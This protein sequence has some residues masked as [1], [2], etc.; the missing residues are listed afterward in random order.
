MQPIEEFHLLQKE[1]GLRLGNECCNNTVL[2]SMQIVVVDDRCNDGSIAAMIRS[3]KDLTQSHKDVSF[4]LQDH[5]F[6]IGP[7]YNDLSAGNECISIS[8]DIVKSPR[9]G[10]AFHLRSFSP[11]SHFPKECHPRAG[12]I[13]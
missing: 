4:K 6:E 9:V 10:D 7:Q 8:L 5:R 1:D 12:R 13:G 11:I 2:S 3:F